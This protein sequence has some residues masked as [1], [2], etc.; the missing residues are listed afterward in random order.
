MTVS[1]VDGANMHTAVCLALFAI[2]LLAVYAPAR[3]ATHV[4][5]VSVLRAD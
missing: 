1:E 2:A 5:P 4:D 3:R